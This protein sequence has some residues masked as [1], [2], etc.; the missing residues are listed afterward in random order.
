[1]IKE[2]PTIETGVHLHST[3]ANWKQ[4]AEAALN[5]GCRRFDG[6]LK[7]IGGCPMAGDD[8]VGNMNT[9]WMIPFFRE[10]NL[11]KGINEDAL[12]ESSALATEIFI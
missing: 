12:A 4:K 7:G 9:E 8:L 3:A 6:A 5:A 10:Q 11:L 2:L 1:M